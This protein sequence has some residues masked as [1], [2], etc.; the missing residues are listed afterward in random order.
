M[1]GLLQQIQELMREVFENKQLSVANETSAKEISEWNSL[2]HVL[3]IAAI[4]KKYTISFSL[5]EMIAFKNVGDIITCLQS[6]I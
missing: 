4:E 6:K 5:D 2:N 3:L 1:E